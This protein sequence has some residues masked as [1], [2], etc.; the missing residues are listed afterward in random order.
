MSHIHLDVLQTLRLIEKRQT[1]L[2]VSP[3]YSRDESDCFKIQTS[4][5]TGGLLTDKVFS[6][7]LS[8]AVLWRMGR[9][10]SVGIIKY[11]V[12]LGTRNIIHIF[13]RAS[14]QLAKFQWVSLRDDP[15][16]PHSMMTYMSGEIGEEP[17]PV[18]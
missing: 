10:L 14:G 13:K 8:Q 3:L 1:C 17:S 4:K 7:A 9:R 11:I 6:R 2:I 16:S 5:L 18:A 12:Y 15:P